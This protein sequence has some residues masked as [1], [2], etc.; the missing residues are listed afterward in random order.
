[1]TEDEARGA[2]KKRLPDLKGVDSLE[3]GTFK[4]STYVTGK[5]KNKHSFL[6]TLM[7]SLEQS[8][9]D[10]ITFLK[11]S[12]ILRKEFA[13]Q[14]FGYTFDIRTGKLTPVT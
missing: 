7:S 3:F 5:L 14:S 8:V 2:V 9:K 10:D 6:L 4:D 11:Q 13:E 12:P 1:M